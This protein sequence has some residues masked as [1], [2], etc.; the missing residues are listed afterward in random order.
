MN[1]RPCAVC[2]CLS[3]DVLHKSFGIRGFAVK[4]ASCGHTAGGRTKKEAVTEWNREFRIG[5]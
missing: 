5:D 4:C 1:K 3:A 2:G